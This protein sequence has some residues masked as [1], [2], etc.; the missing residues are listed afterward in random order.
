M[1][2]G[3]FR[4]GDLSPARLREVLGLEPSTEPVP[5]GV[6]LIRNDLGLGGVFV[7][8]D[9]DEM[10]L[11]IGGDSQIVVFRAAGAE[12]R[13]EWSPARSRTEFLT[14]EGAS[15]YDLVPL[16]I[17]F[18]N[19]KVASLGGGVVGMD[20]RVEMCFDAE[21]PVGPLRRRSD[22][23]IGGQGDDLVPPY[24]RGRPLAGRHPLLQGFQ[25]PARHLRGRAGRRV[26]RSEPRG[27]SPSPRGRP[28]I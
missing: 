12:W 20:G 14:P 25:G 5:D 24:P 6:Y 19:G 22:D 10:I 1:K 4:P 17:V 7:Q 3:V 15:A 23:R 27:A 21:M 26:R 8:G 11:A 9:L 16:P 18:V 13:L 2:I 28:T